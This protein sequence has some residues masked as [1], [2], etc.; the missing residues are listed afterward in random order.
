MTDTM[1]W[2]CREVSAA[3]TEMNAEIVRHTA[4]RT[5]MAPGVGNVANDG[6]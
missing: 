2:V 4:G 5:G 6:A 3:E 1:R